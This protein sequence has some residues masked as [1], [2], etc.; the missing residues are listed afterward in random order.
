MSPHSILLYQLPLLSRSSD[1]AMDILRN[2]NANDA[3]ITDWKNC[4]S[5]S[6]TQLAREI[7]LWCLPKPYWHSRIHETSPPIP[8][9]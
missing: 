5:R 4:A 7:E 8:Q 1:R 3:S 6:L 9:S 2:P